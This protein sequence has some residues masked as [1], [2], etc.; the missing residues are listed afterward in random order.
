MVFSH[1]LGPV[2]ATFQELNPVKDVMERA[3]KKVQ[4]ARDLLALI[5]KGPEI[6]MQLEQCYRL[7][8]EIESDDD[9]MG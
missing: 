2:P 5:G 6:Q 7:I 9:E 4:G 3:K 8:E 1:C